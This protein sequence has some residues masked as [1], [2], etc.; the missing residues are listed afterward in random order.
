[1][2]HFRVKLVLVSLEEIMQQANFLNLI[3]LCPFLKK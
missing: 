2:L 1:M 3:F